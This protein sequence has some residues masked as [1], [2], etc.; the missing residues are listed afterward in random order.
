[1]PASRKKTST[2]SFSEAPPNMKKRSLLP[3]D[4]ISLRPAAWCSF[5]RKNASGYSLLMIILPWI[6]GRIFLRK[7]L[8]MTSGTVST[9][10]GLTVSMAARSFCGV[11]RPRM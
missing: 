6:C 5:L 3:K 10:V 11:G 9:A 1:M 8:S 2:S 7:I 4:L